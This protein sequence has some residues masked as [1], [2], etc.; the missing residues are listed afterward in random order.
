VDWSRDIANCQACGASCSSSQFCGI[1]GCNGV[2]I[3]HLCDQAKTTALLD[4]LAS[5]DAANTVVQNAIL[6]NC[7]PPPT[8]ASAPKGSGGP[9]NAT[10]GQP[11]VGGNHLLTVAGGAFVQPTVA[12][13]DAKSASPV[14]LVVTQTAW[15][16][17]LRGGGADAGTEGGTSDSLLTSLAFTAGSPSHDIFL[18]E[19][20]RD[21][22]SGT[23]TLVMFGQQA[24]TTAAAAWYFANVMMVNLGSY[25]KA[26]YVYE[27]TGTPDAGP[28][29]SD[30]FV[31]KASGP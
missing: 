15:E 17:H 24:E 30:G 11:V 1:S 28:S 18:I 27:W 31:L 5:D 9:T 20:V 16:Y 2:P 29:V 25:D 22:A 12:Y 21:P 8:A 13:L 14:Y 10:T 3:A 6:A 26:W 4:G 23:L 19:L 7:A